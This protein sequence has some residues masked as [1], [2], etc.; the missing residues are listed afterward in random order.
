MVGYT[1][2]PYTTSSGSQ[3]DIYGDYQEFKVYDQKQ[4]LVDI[5]A[6]VKDQTYLQG[7]KGAI[8]GPNGTHKVHL[9]GSRVAVFAQRNDGQMQIVGFFPIDIVKKG[10][11]KAAQALGVKLAKAQWDETLTPKDIYLLAPIL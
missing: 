10:G 3:I 2:K 11:E 1:F 7:L 9:T 8:Y 4:D 6:S 5:Y